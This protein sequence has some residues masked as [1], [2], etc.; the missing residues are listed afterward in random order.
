MKKTKITH[1][2]ENEILKHKKKLHKLHLIIYPTILLNY[3]PK[4]ITQMNYIYKLSIR[5]YQMKLL[6]TNK[7]NYTNLYLN[8]LLIQIIHLYTFQINQIIYTKLH[9]LL[10]PIIHLI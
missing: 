4:S 10:I 8:Q 6:Y 2:P 7:I 9:Q 3:L 5:N 1:V